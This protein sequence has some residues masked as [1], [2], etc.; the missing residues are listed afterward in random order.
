MDVTANPVVQALTNSS[1]ENRGSQDG[2]RPPL[3][4]SSPG[5]EGP[6]DEKVNK[7]ATERQVQPF[8][9]ENAEEHPVDSEG[10]FPEGGLQAWLVVFSAFI[11]LYPSFGFMVCPPSYPHNIVYPHA[12]SQLNRSPSVYCKTTGTKTNSPT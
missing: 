7:T 5:A 6:K 2:R 11:S 12:K 8:E 10:V 4:T 1:E 3:E 9:L